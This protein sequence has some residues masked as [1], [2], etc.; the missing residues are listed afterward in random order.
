MHDSGINQTLKLSNKANILSFDFGET[1]IGIA[2]G[3]QITKTSHPLK[4]IISTKKVERFKAI[5]SLIS[6]WSPGLIVIGLPLNEDGSESRLTILVKKFSDKIVNKFKIPTTLVDER[7]TSV[8]A[9]SLLISSN[10]KYKKNDGA[11][12]QVAAQ[13]ILESYFERKVNDIA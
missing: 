6:D 8:E 7:Y 12:D 13:I 4:T 9:E 2:V 10:G 1:K 5:E 11:V 3:N